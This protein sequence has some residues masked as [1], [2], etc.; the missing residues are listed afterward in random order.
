MMLGRGVGGSRGG[1]EGQ[2]RADVAA[3]KVSFP[4]S[5][6]CLIWCFSAFT[7][8]LIESTGELVNV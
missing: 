4:H 5:F 1:I 7:V 3:L 6:L 2:R 8:H